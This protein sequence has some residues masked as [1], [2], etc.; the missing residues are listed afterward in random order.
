[1]LTFDDTVR[2]LDETTRR[3]IENQIESAGKIKH[4]EGYEP[5]YDDGT[6]HMFQEIGELIFDTIYPEELEE[7]PEPDV[8]EEI[9]L[10]GE[11]RYYCR[12][13]EDSRKFE[14]VHI[15]GYPVW[16]CSVCGRERRTL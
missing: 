2:G 16:R 4:A 9:L 6:P 1:M 13:C 3:I 11:R 10:H 5:E 12:D 8:R 7:T 14:F 15:D